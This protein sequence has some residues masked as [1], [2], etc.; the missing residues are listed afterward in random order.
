M[1]TQ[2]ELWLQVVQVPVV[3]SWAVLHSVPLAQVPLLESLSQHVSPAARLAP[4][5][6]LVLVEPG[7]AS[8]VSGD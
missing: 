2:V 4:L 1:S 8:H 3:A 5:H 6:M 7:T